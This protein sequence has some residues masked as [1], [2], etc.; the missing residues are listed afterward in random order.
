M[1]A[2]LLK[3]YKS[4]PKALPDYTWAIR[5]FL[6]SNGK[7]GQCDSIP[8]ADYDA[9]VASLKKIAE[10]DKP[11]DLAAVDAARKLLSELPNTENHDPL[12]MWADLGPSD[13]EKSKLLGRIQIAS[14]P[15]IILTKMA[16][17]SLSHDDMAA[18]QEFAPDMAEAVNMAAVDVL[19]Q[20]LADG[21]DPPAIDRIEL[22]RM[23]AGA[24]PRFPA[25]PRPIEP[26]SGGEINPAIEA[27]PPNALSDAAPPLPSG[28]A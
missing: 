15:A 11:K 9:T 17:K 4:R 25:E 12:S 10:S 26:S 27:T 28:G 5:D 2:T 14:D 6:R 3:W 18:L 24:P 13:L 8:L 20:A 22:V 19:S 1:T 21:G 23:L 7:C 16:A